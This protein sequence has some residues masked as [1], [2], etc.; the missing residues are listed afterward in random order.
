MN[1]YFGWIF[2]L[3]IAVIP[4][5]MAAKDTNS[6][7]YDSLDQMMAQSAQFVKQREARIASLESQLATAHSL[8]TQY[9]YAYSLFLEYRPF[10]NDLA[11][12]YIEQ[13][14]TL[15]K[16]MGDKA[17]QGNAMSLLA[18]QSSTTGK[19][20][21]SYDVLR[22]IDKEALDAEGLKNYFWACQHLYGEMAYYANVDYLKK[23]YLS[24]YKEYC[25]IVEKSFPHDDDRYL[26]IQEIRMRDYG[27]MKEALRINDQRLAQTQPGTHQYAIVA[28]YRAI[29]YKVNGKQE[30]CNHYLL[31]SALGDVRLAVMDQGSLWELANSL[32]SDK[33]QL[34]RSYEYIKFAWRS[35]TVFNTPVRSRQIMPVLSTIEERYQKQLSETNERLKMMIGFSGVLTLLVLGLLIYVNKQRKRIAVA[36]HKQKETNRQLQTTNEKLNDAIES[37]NKANEDLN[38]ANESL[39]EMNHSLNESNKMKEVYIGRFLRLCALYVDKIETMRKR[40]VKLVKSRELSKL[41]DQMQSDHE[42]VS[43]L[44]DYFDSAFLKL[45]PNFVA[46]FN[47]LLKPEDRI[48]IEDDGKLTT[49]IRIFALIRLGIED[50]SKIAEF[51]HYSVNTIYNYRAKVKSVA[52][53][54]REEFEQKVKEI[55]MK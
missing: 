8:S 30:E 4:S 38:I 11:L 33:K 37:L 5:S 52:L 20:A 34:E 32:I 1:K 22:A 44:Y 7:L 54:N 12:K 14:I 29:I 40:V 50:S 36:H 6:A 48:M 45:F 28:F 47:A 13:C 53:C 2:L 23:Y 35:A 25:G 16:K 24:K 17:K 42:Y 43:E 46:E 26:Q 10:K 27:N 18:F 9:D 39:N 31:L 41:L 19:Y 51:L 3:L 21:E 15:A 55:G 49:T